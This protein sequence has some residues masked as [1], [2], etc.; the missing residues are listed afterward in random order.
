MSDLPQEA[1]RL[2]A[3]KKERLSICRANHQHGF[4]CEFDGD[5]LVLPCSLCGSPDA[6][7]NCDELK[8]EIKLLALVDQQA[9][10]LTERRDAMNQN[11]YAAVIENTRANEAEA[12]RDHAKETNEWNASRCDE[13][14]ALVDQQAQQIAQQRE[15]VKR[16]I[17]SDATPLH[18]HNRVTVCDWCSVSWPK[19]DWR[20][21]PQ[22]DLFGHPV[23]DCLVWSSAAV[24][25]ASAAI[26]PVQAQQCWHPIATA[27]KDGTPILVLAAN[28]E[29][30]VGCWHRGGWELFG[31]YAQIRP[32]FMWMPLPAPPA[33]V[34]DPPE[35]P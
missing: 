5:L 33:A 22:P 7:Y 25:D 2:L 30:F 23:N 1:A 24:L 6:C 11:A 8:L 20:L 3:L 15:K 18:G 28:H 12:D 17:N 16:I 34:L 4:G 10:E 13:L 31:A 9:R 19:P 35:Q 26:E 32:V 29:M 27:P 21:S 14:T